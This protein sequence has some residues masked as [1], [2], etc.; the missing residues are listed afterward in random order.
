MMSLQFLFTLYFQSIDS[1]CALVVLVPNFGLFGR[2]WLT[3]IGVDDEIQYPLHE[4]NWDHWDDHNNNANES[5]E[6]VD[7]HTTICSYGI[8]SYAT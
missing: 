1:N 5:L 2:W 7:H 4:T 6:H 8:G 3:R